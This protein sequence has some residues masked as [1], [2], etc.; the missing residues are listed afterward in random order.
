MTQTTEQAGRFRRFHEKF[1]VEQRVVSASVRRTLVVVAI[2][3]MAVGVAAFATVLDSVL[4]RDGLS[5]IDAPVE[6]WLETSRTEWLTTVMIAIAIAF[7]PIVMPI[8]I[9]ITTVTWGITAKHA[10]RPILLAG[11]ML[12]GVVIVQALAP[13][14]ARERPPVSDMLFGVDTTSS[15]PSGHV[16]GVADFLLITT[17]L[18]FSRHRRP[19]IMVLAFVAASAIVLLTAACRIY[20]GYHWAT[21]ALGSLSLSLVVLGLVIAVD[22]WRTVRAGSPAEVA[23]SDAVREE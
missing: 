23:A 16:M 10:W 4:D 21:D 6:Q 9:V 5:A 8:I 12:L 17:Y 20:L 2:A 11:G 3:L 19:V 1:I 15:F 7:G 13:V 18:V 14:I 22:V